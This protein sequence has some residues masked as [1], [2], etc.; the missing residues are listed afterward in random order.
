MNFNRFTIYVGKLCSAWTNK[1]TLLIVNSYFCNGVRCHVKRSK[2][3]YPSHYPKAIQE[4]IRK[5]G[6]RFCFAQ[7]QWLATCQNLPTEFV[8]PLCNPCFW[9]FLQTQQPIRKHL[10]KSYLSVFLLILTVG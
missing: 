10:Y 8:F 6:E 1:E 4:G 3:R 2:I 7:I 9:H 5:V